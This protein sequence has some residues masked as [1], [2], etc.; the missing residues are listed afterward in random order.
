MGAEV[1]DPRADY[2]EAFSTFDVDGNGQIDAAELVS[3][4]MSL[5]MVTTHIS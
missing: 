3:I 4:M 1:V 2:K 5:E